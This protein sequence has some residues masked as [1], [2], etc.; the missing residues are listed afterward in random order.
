[1]SSRMKNC[2]FHYDWRYQAR[3]IRFHSRLKQLITVILLFFL[4][5]PFSKA[6][7]LFSF[8][9]VASW[10]KWILLVRLSLLLGLS[11]AFPNFFSS[12]TFACECVWLLCSFCNQSA[13]LLEHISWTNS[14]CV[15]ARL[16]KKLFACSKL[17]FPFTY[18]YNVQCITEHKQIQHAN[19]TRTIAF[20]VCFFYQFT[21]SLNFC[22]KKVKE[23]C[24]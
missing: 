16:E 10:L 24:E 8:F 6:F 15:R 21:C 17:L 4:F 5:I 7:C 12:F 22:V 9:V 18:M 23:E 1:M 3:L 2:E 20:S 14:A 11:F 19:K 13:L